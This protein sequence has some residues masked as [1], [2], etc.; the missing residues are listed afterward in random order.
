[1]FVIMASHAKLHAI[2]MRNV[3]LCKGKPPVARINCSTLCDVCSTE[4]C[5]SVMSMGLSWRSGWVL[6]CD[7]CI[8][9]FPNYAMST[10]AGK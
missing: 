7:R 4:Q 2:A 8:T 3:A 5:V 10:L 1:M 9:N 6:A